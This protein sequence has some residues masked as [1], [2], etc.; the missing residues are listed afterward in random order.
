M[1]FLEDMQKLSHCGGRMPSVAVLLLAYQFSTESWIEP[2]LLFDL[3]DAGGVVC[4]PTLGY[5]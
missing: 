5:P 1:C 4:L 3:G 2:M